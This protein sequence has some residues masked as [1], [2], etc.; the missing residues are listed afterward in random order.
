MKG[1]ELGMLAIGAAAI[2]L[3]T[4]SSRQQAYA[5]QFQHIPPMPPRSNAQEYAAWANA[6]IATFGNIA[7]LW[8]PGGPFYGQN[9]SDTLNTAQYDPNNPFMGS[10][11]NVAGPLPCGCMAYTNRFI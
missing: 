5:P 4:G 3:L 8:Q 6:I 7:A 11:S 9:Q 1:N 2:L 10:Y